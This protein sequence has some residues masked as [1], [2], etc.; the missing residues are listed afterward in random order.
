MITIFRNLQTL[1]LSGTVKDTVLMFTTHGLT[2]VLAFFYTIFITRQFNPENFGIF[3]AVSAFILLV[4][5]VLDLGITVSLSRFYPEIK[6]KQGQN[7]A[8]FFLA[9]T[10]KFQLFLTIVTVIIVMT[11]GRI[12]SEA[13]FKTIFYSNLFFFAAIAILTS[14]MF[15][16]S[17]A[18]L[19]A[20]K[21]FLNVSIIL[22]I[23]TLIK[24][25]LVIFLYFQEKFSLENVTAAF[26]LAPL[27]AFLISLKYLNLSKFPKKFSFKLIKKLLA[28][29][30]FI[31]IARVLSAISSRFDALFLIPLSSAYEAGIY[32]AAFKII[33]FYSLLAG[34][35][36]SVIAPRLAGFKTTLE[37]LS[38][39]KKITM[40]VFMMIASLLILYLIAPILIPAVLGIKYLDSVGVFRA[41]LLPT[42][43]FILTIP[44]VNF[45]LYV[46]KKPQITAFNT[47]IQFILLLI[48]NI[49][50]IPKFGRFGP[51]ITLTLAYAF[52]CISSLLFTFYYI[53]NE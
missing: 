14:V 33:F 5:D 30:T 49:Y 39:L 27:I 18:A 13:M 47:L 46:A 28:Y 12:L 24:L 7:M 31:A 26:A 17:T 50:F 19:S 2:S 37:S 35:F 11:L 1:F 32:S 8:M 40:V 41:L 20:Q 51:V 48:G 52:T 4:S 3:S 22:I 23:S 45:L 34:S 9:N 42:G 15:S 29:S 6:Q 10:F 43:L 25:L 38:Y 21:K 36:S 53:K 44:T 16:F